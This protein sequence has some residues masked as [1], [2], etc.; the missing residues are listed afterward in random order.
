MEHRYATRM[1]L[2]VHVLIYR[3]G[4][5]VQA[6]RTRDISLEGAFV[7]TRQF[8]CRKFDC[9]DV[10]F[11]PLGQAGCERFRVK[12][13]VIHRG[14]EGV[15]FEFAALEP[16]SEQSLRNCLRVLQPPEPIPAQAPFAAAVGYR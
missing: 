14:D 13:M 12:A 2:R 15:G 9:L 4:L 3:Q 6:G 1:P 11:L 5:P 8:D 7:E 10:E 16:G